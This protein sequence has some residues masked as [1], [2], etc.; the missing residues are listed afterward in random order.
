[1]MPYPAFDH[2]SDYDMEALYVY[3]MSRTPINH[4]VDPHMGVAKRD[5]P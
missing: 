4:R 3:L 1:M 2:L 5:E